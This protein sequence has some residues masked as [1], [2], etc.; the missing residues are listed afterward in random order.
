MEI[1]NAR[2]M[3]DAIIKHEQTIRA[4]TDRIANLE[5]QTKER[6][7]WQAMDAELAQQGGLPSPTIPAW[8]RPV[9]QEIIDK[10]MTPCRTGARRGK[11]RSNTKYDGRY[12]YWYLTRSPMLSW[13][14]VAR[15]NVPLHELLE[16]RRPE[17]AH[18]LLAWVAGPGRTPTGESKWVRLD[19]QNLGQGTPPYDKAI[20][21]EQASALFRE[22]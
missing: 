15:Y 20:T 17:Y 22:L 16:L 11:G 4:L 21:P 2:Q 12:L 5:Q 19:C 14:S 8:I 3:R 6:D 1:N 13:D 7:E 10:A 9:Q 18:P